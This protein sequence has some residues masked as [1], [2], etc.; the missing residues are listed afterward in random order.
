MPVKP[1]AVVASLLG[2]LLL[3]LVWSANAATA[4]AAAVQRRVAL[5]IGNGGYQHLPGLANPP[6][7]ARLIAKT[8]QSLG[9]ELTGG[10]AQID[11]DKQGFNRAVESF[12]AALQTADVGLFYY[13]GHG[14]QVDGVNWLVPVGAD[15]VAQQDLD[16]Q[17]IDAELVLKQMQLGKTHLN[18]MIL[19]ACRNN[20]F[21][22]RGLR[23]MQSGLA[24]MVAP[25]GTLIAYATQPG[26]VARDGQGDDS[27]FSLALATTM[28]QPGLDV[29][30]LF[31]QVGLTV[32]RETDGEQQPW[33]SS[34][35]IE[36]E[37]Y[38]AGASPGDAPAAPRLEPKQA[39][40]LPPPVQPEPQ[41]SLFAASVGAL[42]SVSH[43]AEISYDEYV[44]AFDPVR[45]PTGRERY[46]MLSRI[47]NASP[48]PELIELKRALAAAPTSSAGAME[49]LDVM[50]PDLPKQLPAADRGAAPSPGQLPL[51]AGQYADAADK[52][53]AVFGPAET[54]YRQSDFKDDDFAK[55]RAM[56]PGLI[57]AFGDFLRSTELLRESVR[58][59]SLAE[60]EQY[61]KQ[62]KADGRVL[63]YD[64]ALTLE[65]GRKLA[66]YI[67]A[68][69][70]NGGTVR[71]I[72]LAG[73]K[74]EIDLFEQRVSDLR[75]R[76]SGDP[77]GAQREYGLGGDTKLARF[78]QVSADLVTESKY[79]WR[80]VR[81]RQEL[82]KQEFTIGDGS[83]G[84]IIGRF[85]SMVYAANNLY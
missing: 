7:D 2:A 13:A 80:S 4:D 66:D 77:D 42:N 70:E 47:I 24:Q 61:L 52:L 26:N 75:E 41:T 83:E 72:D 30:R 29:F 40:I 17:M 57:T 65:Q 58:G 84:D 53:L 21:G 37:F 45:G 50:E 12:G 67:F 51:L 8:L 46:V 22:G 27:P 5:V 43:A 14:L 23:A 48:S 82:D 81:D 15:P 19:D 76:A 9:F 49:Y 56:H 6:N 63:Q 34:S 62:L 71:K 59:I 20:P 60:R 79:L 32:K 10:G 3:V 25:D 55:G 18:M 74:T 31:N 73:L 38:F 36:G 44:A 1:L 35:P 11:L 33:V 78:V 39:L 68:A 69:A 16:F 28:R 85:N 54:Y 64:V